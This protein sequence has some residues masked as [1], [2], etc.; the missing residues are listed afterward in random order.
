[1]L[2]KAS[3]ALSTN[4]DIHLL[5]I[6]GG[7]DDQELQQAISVSPMRNRIH[8]V[9]YRQDAPSLVAAS[10]ASVLPSLKREGLPKTVIESMVYGVVPIVTDT[11]G[12]AELVEDK[13]S[14]LVIAPGD[15]QGLSNAVEFLY[16]NPTERALMGKRARD[17]IASHF[18]VRQSVDQTFEH[19][20][21]L[22]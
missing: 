16:D 9:G 5:L 17:R 20:Q 13:K 22:L 21:R 11:G 18:N 19:L 10:Q 7:L 2:I 6:G 1:M 15:A 14:G 8:C 4:S 3:H 12:S